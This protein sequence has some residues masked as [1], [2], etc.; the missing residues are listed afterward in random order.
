[1]DGSGILTHQELGVLLLD[2]LSSVEGEFE[3]EVLFAVRH[4]GFKVLDAVL[5]LAVIV[6]KGIS[7]SEATLG[8]GLELGL[9]GAQD[10]V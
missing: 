1:L 3:V 2:L 6:E 9:T 10:A 8:R 4:E 5:V 7:Q